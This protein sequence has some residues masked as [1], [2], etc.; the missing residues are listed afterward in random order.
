[1]NVVRRMRPVYDRDTLPK[2]ESE[3]TVPIDQR[4]RNRFMG[5]ACRNI[6][7]IEINGQKLCQRHAASVALKILLEASGSE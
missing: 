2:C 1:M 6:A 4:G 5:R 3:I 7:T